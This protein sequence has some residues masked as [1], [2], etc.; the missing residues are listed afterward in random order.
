MAGNDPLRVRMIVQQFK[1]GCQRRGAVGTKLRRVGVEVNSIDL[2]GAGL[3]NR[4]LKIR[5]G[6][7]MTMELELDSSRLPHRNVDGNRL[8]VISGCSRNGSH[9]SRG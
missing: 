1:N 8:L 6:F 7:L 3:C 5:R 9:Q 2:G 4:L